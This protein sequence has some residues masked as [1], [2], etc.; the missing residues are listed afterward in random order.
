MAVLFYIYHVSCFNWLVVMAFL[1]DVSYLLVFPQYVSYYGMKFRLW[2]HCIAIPRHIVY[3]IG[4]LW[5]HLFTQ[6][7]LT[8]YI[9]AK[10]LHNH[11]IIS[12]HFNHFYCTEIC[13][14]L[15]RDLATYI[16]MWMSVNQ[17]LLCPSKGLNFK[18]CLIILLFQKMSLL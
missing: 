15:K 13:D 2:V 3:V 10:P 18:L 5:S 7:T 8:S 12:V 17:H 14:K 6:N 9:P 1:W 16:S 11:A 4:T